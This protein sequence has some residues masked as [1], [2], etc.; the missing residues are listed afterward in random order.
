M[1]RCTSEAITFDLDSVDPKTLPVLTVQQEMFVRYYCASLDAQLAAKQAGYSPSTILQVST[2]I[3]NKPEIKYQITKRLQS[4]FQAL[5]LEAQLVIQELAIIGFSDIRDC[6]D[7]QG[8][9]IE[10]KNLPDKAARAIQSVKVK[11]RI[12][13]V[14]QTDILQDDSEVEE[15]IEIKFWN[16]VQALSILKNHFNPQIE[17]PG[18]RMEIDPNTL[19]NELKEELYFQVAKRLK[20]GES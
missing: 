10:I 6:F 3:L 7:N 17:M 11:R 2:A 16:K 5:N 19:P 12:K 18:D 15:E 9:F 1:D 13:K 8:N 4:V 14:R 20:S